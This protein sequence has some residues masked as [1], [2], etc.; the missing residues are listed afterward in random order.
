[1]GFSENTLKKLKDAVRS[2]QEKT[3][4]K[5][6]AVQDVCSATGKVVLQAA[7]HRLI[8]NRLAEKAQEAVQTAATPTWRTQATV[9][10]KSRRR[11]TSRFPRK[12]LSK[13]NPR[14]RRLPKS[15]P[16]RRLQRVKSR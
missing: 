12:S 3:E 14:K 5:E 9:W 7:A 1:M 10:G 16:W 13:R 4:G 6:E 15:P 2:V 8:T 11:K